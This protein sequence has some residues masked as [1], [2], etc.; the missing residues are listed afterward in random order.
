MKKLALLTLASL[1]LVGFGC[2]TDMSVTEQTDTSDEQLEDIIDTT[3][4]VSTIDS[5]SDG[6]TD[7]DE[8]EMYQTDPNDTDSDDDGYS[9]GEEVSAGYD[10]NE[11]AITTIVEERANYQD[12]QTQDGMTLNTDITVDLTTTIDCGA[13]A[14]CFDEKFALCEPSTMTSDASGWVAV[15]YE[16]TG[17]ADE[18]CAV[19]MI[20]TTNPNPVWQDKPLHCVYDNTKDFEV[21]MMEAFESAMEIDG[22]C[23]GP[24]NDV[25]HA[26]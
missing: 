13:E 6:I 22:Y 25:F 20:Y 9:D 18:G 19:T 3:P 17:P 1:L 11:P 2:T 12:T 14:S 26:E 24:L 23:S 7:Y 5:D 10:P 21:A 16:I 8:I 4:E 15:S